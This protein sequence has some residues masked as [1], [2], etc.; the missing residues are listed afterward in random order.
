ME[1]ML[2][3][4]A[5]ALVAILCAPV[6]A[7]E[8]YPR[9]RTE[10]RVGA[11]VR[12]GDARFRVEV[13]RGDRDRRYG[14]RYERRSWER[15]HYD[16]RYGRGYY[17][18]PEVRVL[19]AP[20]TFGVGRPDDRREV[21]SVPQPT[22]PR[23]PRVEEAREQDAPRYKMKAGEVFLTNETSCLVVVKNNRLQVSRTFE[24]GAGTIVVGWELADL[25][26]FAYDGETKK[27]Y[28]ME[29]IFSD[30]GPAKYRIVAQ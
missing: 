13:R 22:A 2:K 17:P 15:S 28:P 18:P 27:Y 3:L 19:R 10:V 16:D 12:V 14:S 4:F 20:V 26:A 25:S 30:S 7:Q 6:W 21:V 1:K 8:V 5:A 9:H 24:S 29:I 11:D 23:T